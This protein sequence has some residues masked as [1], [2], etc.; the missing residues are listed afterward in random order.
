[1]RKFRAGPLR[2]NQSAEMTFTLGLKKII[3]YYNHFITFTTYFK[4]FITLLLI[5]MVLLPLLTF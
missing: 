2:R 3:L 1:M 4:L 5:L